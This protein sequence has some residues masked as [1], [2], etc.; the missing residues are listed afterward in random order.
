M[1]PLIWSHNSE[2]DIF[3]KLHARHMAKMIIYYDPH[4]LRAHT[5]AFFEGD[6]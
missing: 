1:T 3:N 2:I 4:L 5:E 6:R